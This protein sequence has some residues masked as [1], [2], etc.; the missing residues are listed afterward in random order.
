ML[1]RGRLASIMDGA[2]RTISPP[3]S[4]DGGHELTGIEILRFLCAFGVLV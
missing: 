1:R 2:L 4:T 3:A